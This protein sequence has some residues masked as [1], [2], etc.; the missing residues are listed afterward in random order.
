MSFA[1]EMTQA[2]AE[3]VAEMGDEVD[4]LGARIMAMVD[5]RGL[6]MRPAEIPEPLHDGFSRWAV[7]TLVAGEEQGRVAVE[8][9]LGEEIGYGGATWTVRAVAPI[10]TPAAGWDVYASTDG[11]GGYR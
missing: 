7:F 5:D 11:R 6:G 4:Y 3:M 10:G 8:P 2:L 1:G 9:C